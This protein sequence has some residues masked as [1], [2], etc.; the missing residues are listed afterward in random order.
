ML[1]FR[2]PQIK[3]GSSSCADG[4]RYAGGAFDGVS[5][6]L[7]GHEKTCWRLPPAANLLAI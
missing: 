4:G 7:I 5:G 3:E 6:A 2:N 1:V